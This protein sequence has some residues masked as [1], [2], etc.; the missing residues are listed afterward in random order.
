MADT[1]APGFRLFLGSH[2]L[3]ETGAAA[4]AV[5]LPLTAA[6][7]LAASTWE[8]AL[9]QAAYHTAYLVFGLPAGAFVARWP[10]R[11]VMIAADGVRCAALLPLPIAF[12]A[13]LLS[14]P[15][16]CVIALLLGSAQLVGDIADHTYLPALVDPGG[17][18]PANS[19]LQAVRSGAELGG[20][21][22][23][24][25]SAQWL[26]GP[27][28]LAAAGAASALSALSL[29]R[30]RTPDRPGHRPEGS[31]AHQVAEGVRFV[32]RHPTLGPL[33]LS[34]SL[35]N[36]VFSAVL[37]LD[38][39]LLTRVAGLPA[40]WTGVL[41]ASGALGALLG[42]SCAT[43][44]SSALGTG[45]TLV[46]AIPLSAPALLLL[47]LVGEGWRVLLFPCAHIS[48][49]VAVT[50]FNILQV[51]HRQRICPPELLSRV[52][53]VFR[54]AVWGAAPL[55][56]VLSGALAQAWG[57]RPTLWVF[58]V[59][60]LVVAPMPAF[61]GLHRSCELSGDPLPD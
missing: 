59:A 34:A 26:G 51:S 40:G 8:I 36:L 27:A 31:L 39:V 48:I 56:A 19:T 61:F 15:L 53:S 23:G 43:R 49:S 5:V 17:L 46:L 13:G 16:L 52:T 38:V 33:A 4:V 11:R 54:F 35:N 44:V 25:L 10:P 24:G 21:G 30:I 14:V 28:A 58:A 60:L 50:V 2:V 32:V 9:V 57:V 37:A 1:R 12:A 45:R 20:P 6:L 42:A 29:W 3:N 7:V 18:V 47:P 55:G 22:L 41:L